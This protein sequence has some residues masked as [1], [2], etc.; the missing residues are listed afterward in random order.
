MK[1][2][3]KSQNRKR[4]ERQ[5]D[6][7]LFTTAFALDVLSKFNYQFLLNKSRKK[8][9]FGINFKIKEIKKDSIQFYSLEDCK[10]LIEQQNIVFDSQKIEKEY[11]IMLNILLFLIESQENCFVFYDRATNLNNLHSLL[12][13]ETVIKL[14]IRNEV[15][16]FKD[17]QEKG[18]LIFESIQKELLVKDEFIFGKK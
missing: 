1:K 12:L 4:K 8:S 13:T 9:Y 5:K 2:P 11:I 17:I 3:N 14:V 10:S 16:Y 15:F 7:R 6:K 18:K